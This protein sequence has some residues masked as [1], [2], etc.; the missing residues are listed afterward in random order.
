MSGPAAAE[1]GK[2]SSSC[3]RYGAAV[4]EAWGEGRRRKANVEGM[5]S[6]LMLTHKD[7]RAEC[8]GCGLKSDKES[9]LASNSRHV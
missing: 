9:Q 2:G 5:R 1:F 7:L 4:E 3:S 6:S 8:G